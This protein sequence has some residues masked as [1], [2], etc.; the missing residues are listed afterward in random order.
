VRLR[1]HRHSRVSSES[2]DT[3]CAA[4][5]ALIAARRILTALVRDAEF[6]ATRGEGAASAVAEMAT[7]EATARAIA[8]KMR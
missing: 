5:T 2:G 8:G 3:S 6:G 7:D 4:R 1:L